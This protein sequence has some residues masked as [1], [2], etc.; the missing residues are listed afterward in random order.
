VVGWIVRNS[1]VMMRQPFDPYPYIL[2]NLVLSCLAALQA[3]VRSR[4]T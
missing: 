1:L 3:P 4:P 2:L